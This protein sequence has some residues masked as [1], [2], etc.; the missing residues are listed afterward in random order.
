MPTAV[1]SDTIS[2]IRMTTIGVLL[3]KA[4]ATAATPST[5]TTAVRGRVF[6]RLSTRPASASSVPVRTSAA[7]STSIAP[8]ATAAGFAN[9]ASSPS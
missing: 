6:A 9:A 1:A 3:T 7:E 2:G 5:A 4:D 8:I